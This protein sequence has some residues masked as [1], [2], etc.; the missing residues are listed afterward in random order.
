MKS[1]GLV[2]VLICVVVMLLPVDP[3]YSPMRSSF[4][5]SHPSTSCPCKWDIAKLIEDAR[6]FSSVDA[7]LV[8]ANA[9]SRLKPQ[10]FGCSTLRGGSETPPFLLQ[11][12]CKFL[13]DDETEE[14]KGADAQVLQ[15]QTGFLKQDNV[16]KG[17]SE[18]VRI[19]KSSAKA[20][21]KQPLIRAAKF[22]ESTKE[23]TNA[24]NGVQL[25]ESRVQ[26]I[27]TSLAERNV[28][29]AMRVKAIQEIP[30]VL[31]E[32]ETGQL[33]GGVSVQHTPV[34]LFCKFVPMICEQLLDKRSSLVKETCGTITACIQNI[35]K[36]FDSYPSVLLSSLLQLTYVTVKV[37]SSASWDCIH[38]IADYL[39]LANVL[40]ELD[41]GFQD[42]HLPLRH[43]CASVLIQ[44][45]RNRSDKELTAHI[46]NISRLVVKALNDPSVAVR[47]CGKQAVSQVA[48]KFPEHAREIVKQTSANMRNHLLKTLKLEDFNKNQKSRPE[49]HDFHSFRRRFLQKDSSS[50]GE[51]SATANSLPENACLNTD[52]PHT[53]FLTSPPRR[54]PV[55]KPQDQSEFEKW[56]LTPTFRFLK[57][58]VRKIRESLEPKKDLQSSQKGKLN[59]P[60]SAPS[61]K[62][63]RSEPPLDHSRKISFDDMD[64]VFSSESDNDESMVGCNDVSSVERCEQKRVNSSTALSS[65]VSR[66][67]KS[68][69]F[70][71]HCNRETLKSQVPTPELK[72]MMIDWET[73]TQKMVVESEDDKS[74]GPV[75]RAQDSHCSDH[76]LK[77]QK[78]TQRN[79][80]MTKS[81]RDMDTKTLDDIAAEQNNTPSLDATKQNL[82]NNEPTIL[83]ASSTCDEF[84]QANFDSVVKPIS[85]ESLLQAC[86]RFLLD[87][88]FAK[89]VFSRNVTTL[90]VKRCNDCSI[91]QDKLQQQMSINNFL[92][93]ALLTCKVM[94]VNS[95]RKA[96][97]VGNE[98]QVNVNKSPVSNDEMEQDHDQADKRDSE[99]ACN[100]EQDRFRRIEQNKKALEELGLT[101][102]P[103]RRET[104]EDLSSLEKETSTWE[105]EDEWKMT[106]DNLQL[107]SDD[108]T[109]SSSVSRVRKSQAVQSFS[110]QSTKYKSNHAGEDVVE[111]PS[112]LR[113][114]S[115]HPRKVDPKQPGLSRLEQFR[116]EMVRAVYE[117]EGT[118]AAE[119]LMGSSLPSVVTDAFADAG[120]KSAEHAQAN[121][122]LSKEER[123]GSSLSDCTSQAS[124]V[125]DQEEERKLEKKKKKKTSR[126]FRHGQASSGGEVLSRRR[127]EKKKRKEN[128]PSRS[129]SNKLQRTEPRE[130][131]VGEKESE[132]STTRSRTNTSAIIVGARGM[133]REPAL[134]QTGFLMIRWK[135]WG[136]KLQRSRE[137]EAHA[138]RN[139]TF[140]PIE[141]FSCEGSRNWR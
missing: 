103:T 106:N 53:S 131:G 120:W 52:T 109:P 79:S 58:P 72:G 68:F 7:Q 3:L 34:N 132:A 140:L 86:D 116:A 135:D 17:S 47:S 94:C 65:S 129:K 128:M 67:A 40:I 61:E 99:A 32:I 28:D 134:H 98:S 124:D 23:D 83:N 82:K 48:E 22:S 4:V 64:Y 77:D 29:W 15:H 70:E 137:E 60:C 133:S 43:C 126:S 54:V 62:S 122:A 41:R 33:P 37:I 113:S 139:F 87:N 57:T 96:E 24:L 102:K 97:V 56:M 42:L 92:L 88:E 117:S 114:L 119:E 111:R 115:C 69:Q 18:S 130:N 55:D 14:L 71:T 93:A 78:V 10:G 136:G 1:A 45:L 6:V 21:Q 9:V 49:D 46:E 95:P 118:S 59:R 90:P 141:K 125:I 36:A 110:G 63:F 123:Q 138:W 12:T 75:L 30:K 85:V 11:K 13:E 35:G 76:H 127:L 121:S 112:R 20:T 81:Q 101:V 100:Y 8:S 84:K 89:V 2:Q 66:E 50:A 5:S 31:K 91:L 80:E 19:L 108:M 51:E 73:D 105:S 44:T 39:N 26:N 38:S 107:E 74:L 16:L 25:W 104:R 27:E